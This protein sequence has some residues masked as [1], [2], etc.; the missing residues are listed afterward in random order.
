MFGLWDPEW[1]IFRL[2]IGYLIK[3]CQLEM[4]RTSKCNPKMEKHALLN[5]LVS[6][7]WISG[8]VLD[9]LEILERSGGAEKENVKQLSS[10]KALGGTK[11]THAS[12]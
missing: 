2:K 4:S 6:T 5:I 10:K 8:G 3:I 11:F 7:N 12:Y 1:A 9:V